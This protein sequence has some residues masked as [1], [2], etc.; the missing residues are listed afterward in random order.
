LFD[1]A[2]AG[3]DGSSGR[4]SGGH[5]S[6]GGGTIGGDEKVVG[7]DP[8]GVADDDQA[9]Q[10]GLVDGVPEDVPDVTSRCTGRPRMSMVTLNDWRGW[11]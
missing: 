11:S 2:E 10:V 4:R 6:A 1:V 7:F 8:V 3:L 5:G 9:V